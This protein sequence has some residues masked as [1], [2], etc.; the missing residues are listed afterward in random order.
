MAKKDGILEQ[1]GEDLTE[2][3]RNGEL[4]PIVG[5]DSEIKRICHCS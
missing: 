2:A 5:R 1:Y 4:D 3:A